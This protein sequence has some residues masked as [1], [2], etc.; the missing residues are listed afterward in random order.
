MFVSVLT[1]WIHVNNQVY[2]HITLKKIM[3]D[4]KVRVGAIA[5]CA[6]ESGSCYLYFV[7][8]NKTGT[9]STRI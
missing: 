6:N 5:S 7:C 8:I 1:N 2:L 4:V 3:D 9:H